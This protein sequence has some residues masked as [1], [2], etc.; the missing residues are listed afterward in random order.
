M[1]GISKLNSKQKRTA[2]IVGVIILIALTIYLIGRSS[3]KKGKAKHIDLPTDT[4]KP[5]DNFGGI[6]ASTIRRL[7]VALHDDM[8]GWNLGGHNMDPYK[9]WLTMSDT[10]FVAV[11]NDFNDQF[12]SEGKGTLRKWIADEMYRDSL[13]DDAVLPRMAKLNL[14]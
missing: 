4:G 12:Y 1:L 6:P 11:Y 3:G 8:D 5:G 13:I 9:E 14:L 2:I 7:S 10:G